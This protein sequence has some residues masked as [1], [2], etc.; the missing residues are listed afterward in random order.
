MKQ[1]RSVYQ[2]ALEF[3]KLASEKKAFTDVLQFDP[4]TSRTFTQLISNVRK[5]ILNA[6]RQR[7]EKDVSVPTTPTGFGSAG[8]FGS[9]VGGSRRFTEK[10]GDDTPGIDVIATKAAAEE[11]S[12]AAAEGVV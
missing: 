12:S 1:N 9:S 4:A 7:M 6:S 3:C 5:E 10:Y 8:S 2:L 11:A